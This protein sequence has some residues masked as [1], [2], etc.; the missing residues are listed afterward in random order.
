MRV[1]IVNIG[2]IVSGD[3]RQPLMAGDTVICEDG[4]ITA[5]GTSSPAAVEG[6]DV[7]IDAG[8]TTLMPGLIDSHVHITFGDYTPRQQVVGY[9]ESYV[10][11]G[12]TTAI[13][14]SEVH[15]PGRPKDVD[16]VKA[17]AVAAHKCFET[18]R[19]GGMRVHAGSVILEPGLTEADFADLRRQG[20]WLAKAG[21]GAMKTAY[22]YVPLVAAARAAGMITTVHTGGSSIPG[23]GAVTGD[24][25]LAM[26]P[27]VS[28]HV[29]GGPTA[30]KDA[31]FERLVRDSAIALQ[32]CTAGNLR[33]ALLT[34][35]LAVSHDAFDRLLIATDTPT[36]SGIMP[37]GMLYTI[38]HLASLGR[39][40]PELAIAAATGNNAQ[41]YGLNAG[42]IAVGRDADLVLIDAPDGGSQ[43]TALAAI[44]N[45]DIAAIGAVVTNGEP[46]FVGRSRN[47]PATTRSVRVAS[48]RV[49]MSYGAARH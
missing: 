12:T 48:C 9:L 40:A 42:R 10:H 45:G 4:L 32:L 11:G 3:W 16:G 27:H 37:L 36:G 34:A 49:P 25:L 28:F 47:S 15:V 24:H 19:P 21:F 14:A 2:A 33:T 31:D 46:R 20:V 38:S 41:V 5:V 29:N 7:V 22:D 8:G 39:V 6:A 23:S 35:S 26:N 43:A 44:A 18:Y 13:S 1:A 17:L 30:M